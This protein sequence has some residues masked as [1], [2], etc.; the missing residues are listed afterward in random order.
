MAEGQEAHLTGADSVGF[1]QGG[2][3]IAQIEMSGRFVH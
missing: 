3:E 1:V 2:G